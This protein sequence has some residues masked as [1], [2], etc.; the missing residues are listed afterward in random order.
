I[1]V[2]TERGMADTFGSAV[3][4]AGRLKSR[5][6][7]LKEFRGEKIIRDLSHQGITVRVKSK[8]GA[9]EEAP[10]AYKDVDRVVGIMEG[11]GVNRRVV[12]LKPLICIKG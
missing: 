8:R 11:A 4:G 9:A 1:L 7:A 2:G 3:H 5:K 6:K 12:K 10:G